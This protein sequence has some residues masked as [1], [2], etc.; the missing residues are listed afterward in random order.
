[1]VYKDRPNKKAQEFANYMMT[2]KGSQMSICNS[3]KKT[4]QKKE[5]QSWQRKQQLP[6]INGNA[7]SKEKKTTKKKLLGER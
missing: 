5:Y 1:M 6:I 3:E 4:K 2:S 7:T